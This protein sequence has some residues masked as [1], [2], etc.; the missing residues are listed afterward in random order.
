MQNVEY[1]YFSFHHS[2]NNLHLN[3]FQRKQNKKKYK[4]EI[5]YFA[6]FILIFHSSSK[7]THQTINQSG[8]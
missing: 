7:K 6:K 8:F 5:L 2:N 1:F 4:I 3:L